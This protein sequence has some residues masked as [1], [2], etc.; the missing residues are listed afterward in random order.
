MQPVLDYLQRID[1]HPVADHYAIALLTVAVLIDLFASLVPARIWLR[2]AA[3]LLTILGALS[4]GASYGT[5]TL[6]A[7]R[8]WN[9]LGPDAKDILHRHGQ[10]GEYL[11]IAFGV[12]ALWRIL[13]QAVTFFAGSRT[14][15]L[16]VAIVAIGALTYQA[17]LGGKLV[18]NYGAGTAL[19]ANEPIPKPENA[20]EET[21]TPATSLPTVTVPTATPTAPAT[22]ASAPSPASATSPSPAPSPTPT[23]T[24]TASGV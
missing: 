9:A 15:Y 3:L 20:A 19:M 8:I 4:A 1:L 7:G 17:Y 21:P 12:L 23:A 11:A 10:L 2:Y 14:F 18:Y 24:P 6:E 5:G 16:L 13:I 22:P